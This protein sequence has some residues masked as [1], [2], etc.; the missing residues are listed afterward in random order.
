M[1]NESEK[2]TEKTRNVP[3]LRFAGFTNEWEQQKLNKLLKERNEQITA[4][5]EY[6]LM[7]FIQGIGVTPK[8]ER[9]DRSF[10]VKNDQKKYKK[11]ELG[12][13]IYSSNNLETGS[14]GLNKTGKAVISPV[15]SIFS[16]KNELESQ[17]IGILSKR[18]DFIDKMIHYRQGVMYGQWRIHESDFLKVQVFVPNYDEQLKIISFFFSFKSP[19]LSSST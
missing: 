4:C 17:F 11:T 15:Y 13:F 9:Y 8:G 2:K 16:S 3:Q 19:Y 10:L 1:L 6:P 18:K 7:S 5:E 14:I 12:D